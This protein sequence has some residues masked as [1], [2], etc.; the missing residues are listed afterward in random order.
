MYCI[1]MHYILGECVLMLENYACHVLGMSVTYFVTGFN[2]N[3]ALPCV[4][5][6]DFIF[7][8]I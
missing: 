5:F 1:K 6:C 3:W 2:F 8:Y 4:T 7:L